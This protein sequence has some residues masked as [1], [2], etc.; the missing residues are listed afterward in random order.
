MLERDLLNKF[1]SVVFQRIDANGDGEISPDE[2]SK[3]LE[4]VGVKA[5]RISAL[6]KQLDA[7]GN[8]KITPEEF[9]TGFE[10]LAKCAP[11]RALVNS[12]LLGPGDKFN[13]EDF[14]VVAN[15]LK[16]SY[17]ELKLLPT[18]QL[19]IGLYFVYRRHTRLGYNDDIDGSTLDKS[20]ASVVKALLED[21]RIADAVYSVSQEDVCEKTGLRPETVRIMST[22]SG[23]LKVAHF[24]AVQDTTE[25]VVLALRGT[26][27]FADVITDL[28]CTS[29]PLTSGGYAHS[30]MLDAARS[31]IEHV[32][33]HLKQL[34]TAH[35]TYSLRIIGHSL[36]AGTAALTAYLLRNLPP[37]D[38][39]HELLPP[40]KVSAVTFATP[41]CMS[42]E[43]ALSVSSYVTTVVLQDDI[44]PRTSLHNLEKLQIE[45]VQ[46]DWLEEIPEGKAKDMF[47]KVFRACTSQKAAEAIKKVEA[48]TQQVASKV[49]INIGTFFGNGLK[50]PSPVLGEGTPMFAPGK[51]YHIRRMDDGARATLV[52]GTDE[53]AF[54][55]VVLSDTMVSD[56][57]TGGE[58][59]Y[60]GCLERVL[61]QLL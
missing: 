4:S 3:Y 29:I 6:F 25:S 59:A 41:A 40:S 34:L 42:S 14:L 18:Y 33:E 50:E 35:P 8:G 55:S 5:D 43:V 13:D 11:A 53:S 17:E 44:V 36:G 38:P 12:E 9:Q 22:E 32:S 57:L 27:N 56:H 51:L 49:G 24:I 39:L 7:D 26:D 16:N 1:E 54:R 21:C 58:Q 52:E 47:V 30:G 48:A 46:A 23:P 19:V 10:H 37:S 45:I 15:Q 31:V 2:L 20:H 60:L 61:T 28:C